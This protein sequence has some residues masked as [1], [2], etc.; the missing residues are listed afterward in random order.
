MTTSLREA[1][2]RLT[3]SAKGEN[4][5]TMGRNVFV[6]MADLTLVLSTLQDALEALGPFERVSP[7]FQHQGLHVMGRDGRGLYITPTDFRRAAEVYRAL[8][9]GGAD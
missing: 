2:E 5:L 8:S 6:Q 3:A 9:P 1:V 4:Q 7:R